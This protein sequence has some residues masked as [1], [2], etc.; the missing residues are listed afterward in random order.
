M[1]HITL[2][3]LTLN[4]F[5]GIDH[6]EMEFGGRGASI[7]GDNA[8]GKT[9]VYD[10]YLWLLT[11]RDSLGRSDFEIKPL[12]SLGRIIDHAARSTV[13]AVLSV[14]GREITLRREYYEVW[15]RKRGRTEATYDGNSTDFYI[16]GVPKAK[17]AYENA[18]EERCV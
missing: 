17:G 9:T 14:D 4:K 3:R 15:S 1:T 5:K 8:S 16:N 11:G 12:D 10:A 7:Y 13:E 2:Q 6:L 18:V